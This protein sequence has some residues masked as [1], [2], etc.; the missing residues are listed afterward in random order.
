M[1]DLRSRALGPTLPAPAGELWPLL[2]APRPSI[3]LK[4]LR[5]ASPTD[6]SQT[7]QTRPESMSIRMRDCPLYDCPEFISP[8]FSADALYLPLNLAL[9][10]D[11][12]AADGG[13][14]GGPRFESR[15]PRHRGAWHVLPA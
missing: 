8:E 9:V 11:I 13:A 5:A 6:L 14:D 3:G 7:S 15:H 4:W 12:V 10:R 2:R 1:V